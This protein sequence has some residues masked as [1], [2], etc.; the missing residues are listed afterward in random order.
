VVGRLEA[1]IRGLD[2]ELSNLMASL[3][4]AQRRLPAF[5]ARLGQDFSDT[6]L[7]EEK[8]QA[9]ADLEAE[10]ASTKGEFEPGNDN[11]PLTECAGNQGEL[12]PPPAVSAAC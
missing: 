8:L 6:A 10:L 2:T 7:L 9:L 1:S 5:E 11:A 4:A 12:L 3:E